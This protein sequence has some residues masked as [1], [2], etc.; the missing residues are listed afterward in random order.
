MIEE[1]DIQPQPFIPKKSNK[2]ICVVGDQSAIP[3]HLVKSF[4]F[5]TVFE[6]SLCQ[7][8]F[9]LEVYD[10]IRSSVS[11]NIIKWL[12]SKKSEDVIVKFV[13]EDGQIDE[14]WTFNEVKPLVYFPGKIDYSDNVVRV[15][16]VRF[17]CKTFDVS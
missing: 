9:G 2:W 1:F 16:Q 14:T 12:K 15:V 7:L 5:P 4:S 13:T 17:S 10:A 8:E 6:D 3:S 11:A